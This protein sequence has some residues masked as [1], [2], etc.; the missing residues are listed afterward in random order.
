MRRLI[1]LAL[2]ALAFAPAAQ[3]AGKSPVFGLRAAGSNARG[4]FVYSLAAGR[5]QTGAVIVSNAGTATG[6]VK[7]FTADATT[8]QT[9]GTVYETDKKPARVGSWVKL[10]TRSLTLAPGQ[11]RRVPFTL[12]VPA[13]QKAGQWV[14]GI[15][16]ETLRQVAKSKSKQKA[17]VQIRIRDLT[18]VAV[19]ANVPG[20][21][22]V[23]FTFGGVSTGGERGFQQV[24]V[25]VANAG[26]VLLKPKGTATIFDSHGKRVETL[27]FAMDTFLPKTAID[28]PILLRQA[29]AAGDYSATVRLSA[30]RRTFSSKSTFSVSK[31]DVKQ[32][33]TSASPTQAPPVASTEGGASSTPWGLIAAVAAL[34]AIVVL[35]GLW[36]LLRRRKSPPQRL[37]A[38]LD[39]APPLQPEPEPEPDV[40]R[41]PEAAPA[42]P[43]ARPAACDPDHYWEVAY[44]RPQLGDDGVWRFPHTCRTC[45][46]E[47][48][49][50]DV[51]DASVRSSSP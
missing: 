13:G 1:A 7:L 17:S 37:R 32:V 30:N 41:Q 47:V 28:Y 2:A 11:H 27:P 25:H 36:Q 15:V 6:T 49:A 34:V 29:L 4:Y 31:E 18:I 50:S 40:D 21:K 39:D 35:L 5:T 16:A 22:V 12:H 23:S 45:G 42:P 8:G 14:G 33:F 10:S 44:D 20:Q 43:P 19:Q 26:N 24:V 48:L 51:A 3:A 9:T 46:L 38:A